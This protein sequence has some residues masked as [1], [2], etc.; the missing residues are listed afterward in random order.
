[1][2]HPLAVREVALAGLALLAAAA[3]LAVTAQTRSDTGGGPQPEGSYVALAGSSGPAAFGR[4]TAC[5]GTI[6]AETQGIAHPT[7]PCGARLFVTYRGTTVLTQVVDRGPYLPGRQFDLTDALARR[8]G[9]RG[10][11]VV[12]WAYARAQ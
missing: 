4:R 7:L 3:A 2:R 11:Q 5:G 9:L 6:G 8:L 10:V 12:R 1:M